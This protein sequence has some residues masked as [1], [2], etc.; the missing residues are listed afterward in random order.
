MTHRADALAFGYESLENPTYRFT[1]QTKGADKRP[2]P[3]TK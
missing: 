3:N 1:L 2:R